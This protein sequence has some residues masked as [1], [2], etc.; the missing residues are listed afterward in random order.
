MTYSSSPG[1]DV[2][3]TEEF[4]MALGNL[5]AVALQNGIDPRGAWEFR[6]D[7]TPPDWEVM[8]VELQARGGSD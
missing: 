4:E 8:V 6:K 7:G 3:T 1:D 5:L 2:T